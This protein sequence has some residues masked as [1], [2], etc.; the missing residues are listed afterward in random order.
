M[1]WPTYIS[2]PSPGRDPAAAG[3]RP[4]QARIKAT[5]HVVL[6]ILLLHSA[7]F[8]GSAQWDEVPKGFDWNTAANW[9]PDTVPNGPADEATL[10]FST[11]TN[12]FVTSATE[13]KSVVFNLQ[14]STYTIT[15]LQGLTLNIRG[16]GITNLSA[17]TQNFVAGSQS[18]G[19]FGV[20]RFTNSA[21]VGNN[22]AFATQGGLIFGTPGPTGIEFF[23]SSNAGH[24]SFTNNGSS[25]PGVL[26]GETAFHD[27]S[28]AGNGSFTN[29]GANIS[30]SSAGGGLVEFLDNSTAGNATFTND[31]ATLF[32]A[33]G[34]ETTFS[35][36]SD[37]GDATFTNNGAA[38]FG[39]GIGGTAFGG[40]SSGGHSTVINNGGR[41]D[42]FGNATAASATLIANSAANGMPGGSIVFSGDALGGT[43]RVELFGEGLLEVSLHNAPGFTIGSLEGDGDVFFGSRNL[44]V[45]S[46]NRSTEFAGVIQEGGGRLPGGTLTKV[47]TGTLILQGTN[48]FPGVTTLNAGPLNVE[49]SLAGPVVVNGGVLGGFGNVGT[50]MVNSGGTLSPGEDMG[51]L[52]VHG[53]LV[54][55]MGSTYVA[56][57]F[58]PNLGAQYTQANVSGKITLNK[59]TLVV[60]LEYFP[61]P[62]T[63][64]TII[65]N[66]G[67]D[68]VKGK[69]QGLGEGAKFTVDGLKFKIS[70]KG[71]DGNDVVIATAHWS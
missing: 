37:A 44:T 52:N 48:T 34:G 67:R 46:N 33:R 54:M 3:S 14:A 65:K 39:V 5:V 22:I 11:L 1:L 8:A 62:G 63:R 21:T 4:L 49:G 7:I 23:N 6:P 35:D 68:A 56:V 38:A 45:G 18:M 69:F 31:A 57:L 59:C 12:L 64:Y 61:T 15:A 50:V 40:N 13:V 41:T 2:S 25:N 55:S 36:N 10:G 53:Q 20:L 30:T 9:T 70:Y 42:F 24:G 17:V 27:M 60:R 26:E 47:G 29:K 19:Q 51:I 16:P 58:G 32:A 71:G 43:A 28:S 66:D